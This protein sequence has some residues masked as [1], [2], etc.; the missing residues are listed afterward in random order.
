METLESA[1]QQHGIK[2]PPFSLNGLQTYARVVSINNDGTIEA[3]IPICLT[4]FRFTVRIKGVQVR[5]LDK[6]ERKRLFDVF[7]G[8][9]GSFDDPPFLEKQV[10][11]A[12]L[13]CGKFDS[14]GRLMATA[15]S[16]HDFYRAVCDI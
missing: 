5:E 16:K 14:H 13:V 11:L 8:G 12:R 4:Y 10:I 9:E 3:V 6:T 7:V 15:F 2:T 1:F